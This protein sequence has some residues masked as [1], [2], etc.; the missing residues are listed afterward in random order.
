V[1]NII[2][3]TVSSPVQ[4]HQTEVSMPGRLFYNSNTGSTDK[5]ESENIQGVY[6]GSFQTAIILEAQ[7]NRKLRMYRGLYRG[8][9]DSNNTG[10]TDKQENEDIQG[11]YTGS[12]R[13]AIILEAHKQEIEDVQGFIRGVSR[14]Q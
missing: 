10:N 8:F 9:S 2:N 6:T 11:I 1:L 13:T 12:F 7:I 14:Q 5:Q 4:R 3:S